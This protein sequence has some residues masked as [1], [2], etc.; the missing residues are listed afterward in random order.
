MIYFR[1]GIIPGVIALCLLA[2]FPS[3]IRAG[4]VT[5]HFENVSP[6]VGNVDFRH[7]GANPGNTTAGL[8]NWRTMAYAGPG[9]ADAGFYGAYPVNSR[10]TTFC[11]ELT[12]YASGNIV[13]SIVDL[14]QVP[15]PGN[16][17]GNPLN[18]MGVTKANDLKNLFARYYNPALLTTNSTEA[19]AFQVATWEIVHETHSGPYNVVEG[20]G[21]FYLWND[22]SGVRTRAQAMLTDLSTNT[23]AWNE[24]SSLSGKQLVG[25]SSGSRQDQIALIPGDFGGGGGQQGQAVPAPPGIVLA[26]IGVLSLLGWVRRRT[27]AKAT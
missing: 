18:G 27:T 26:G 12:Q 16:N 17:P 25:L 4:F 7:G 1:T 22:P 5:A 23:Y 8:M 14:S 24:N 19:A 9:Q 3:A 10:F 13:F 15:M 21:N 2:G 20:T 6:G 11:V